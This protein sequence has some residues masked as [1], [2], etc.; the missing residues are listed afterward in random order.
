VW[1][2][3]GAQYDNEDTNYGSNET[4]LTHSWTSGGEDGWIADAD[5]F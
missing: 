4:L 2:A 3:N 5:R 1:F